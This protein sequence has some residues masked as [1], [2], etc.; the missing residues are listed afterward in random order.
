MP[1]LEIARWLNGKPVTLASL[2]GKVVVLGV[3]SGY[4]TE[5]EKVFAQLSEMERQYQGQGLAVAAVVYPSWDET[6]VRKLLI[7]ARA[8]YPVGLIEMR[9]HTSPFRS[10][11]LTNLV[12][13]VGSVPYLVID[14]K[15]FAKP[16]SQS[17]QLDA[18]VRQALGR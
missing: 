7:A 11:V 3:W 10:G 4:L 2:K 8:D 16:V 13:M 1:E 9:S 5:K 12:S 14:R 6:Y 17:N 18:E 15:G